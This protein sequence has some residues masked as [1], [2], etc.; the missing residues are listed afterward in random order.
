MD[1]RYRI[2]PA[3]V[4]DAA[5]IAEIERACF[6]DPWT[7]AG[8]AETLQ[9]GTTSTFLVLEGERAA[10]YLMFRVSGE[11]AEILNLAVMPGDRRQ[12][13]ARGLLEMGL[14]LLAQ[15]GATESFL[16]VRESNRAAI[17]LYRRVGF[18]PVALRPDYYRNPREDALVLRL[19]LDGWRR[20]GTPGVT[21]VDRT[22]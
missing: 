17:E 20:P 4:A 10:G 9:Y 19:S 14:D 5:A 8:L 12:G 21:L 16:E 15:A 6:T 1:V 2:R 3:T 7:A 11:E 18:R 13:I 22:T